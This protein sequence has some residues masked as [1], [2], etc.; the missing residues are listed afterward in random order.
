MAGRSLRH[1]VRLRVAGHRLRRL[2]LSSYVKSAL[3]GLLGVAMTRLHSCRPW[4]VLAALALVAQLLA[5]C[6]GHGSSGAS[7]TAAGKTPADR[8][9]TST[10]SSASWNPAVHCVPVVTTLARIVGTQ[11]SSTGGATQAGGWYGGQGIPT[12]TALDPPCTVG[13]DPMFVELHNVDVEG[14]TCNSFVTGDGDCW[15]NLWDNS[16]GRMNNFNQIHAEIAGTWI[17]AGLSPPVPPPGTQIDVQG[18]VYWD[19]GHLS[20]AWHSDSGWELHPVAAWRP[21]HGKVSDDFAMSLNPYD[22]SVA[23]GSTSSA[24]IA[25]QVIAGRSQQ[26]TLTA[27]RVP[28][29]ATIR[30]SPPSLMTGGSA[31]I[32]ITT[33]ANTPA[34]TYT[35]TITATGPGAT[36]S[37]NYPLSVRRQ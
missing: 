12:K 2:G 13:G 20:D 19:S 7:A 31:V 16:T 21:S 3:V 14:F 34:D 23:A 24:L 36:H 27:V 30:F 18:F 5:G 4:A 37:V 22:G 15:G 10:R 32:A 6:G 35:V 11:V 8:I 26:V 17:A 1:V 33:A 9:T 25:T 29:G 28:A